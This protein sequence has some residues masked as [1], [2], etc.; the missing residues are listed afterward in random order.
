MRIGIAGYGVL[1]RF[2]GQLMSVAAEVI[3]YDPPKGI[4]A[5]SDLSA[6]DYVIITVPTP[7]G[8][9]GACD[10]T[11]VEEIVRLADPKRGFICHST[12]AVGTTDRLLSTCGKN[13]VFVPEYAGESPDHPYRQL[14]NRRFF[15]IGGYEPFATQVQSLY[16]SVYGDRTY[17]KVPPCYAELT[18][19]MEN[20]FLALKVTFCNEFAELASALGLDYETVRELWLLDD[21]VTA[22]H[23]TVTE[24]R[25]FGGACLPKD[26]AAICATAADAGMSMDLLE[27]VRRTNARRRS[28][29]QP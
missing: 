29:P 5:L 8:P 9:D 14:P 10:A 16:E 26:L 19:Y 20:A 4:G 21:R 1:G 18:K 15:I 12:V 11:I 7:V 27:T 25:G 24:E 17:V 2:H 6:C 13:L 3:P 23:T 28:L 22:S